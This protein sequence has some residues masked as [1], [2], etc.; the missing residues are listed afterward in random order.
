MFYLHPNKP[1]GFCAAVLE[2]FSNKVDEIADGATK[3]I[4]EVL[5]DPVGM[6]CAVLTLIVG[7]IRR[8]GWYTLKCYGGILLNYYMR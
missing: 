7:L 6:S 4:Q 1:N 5:V 8:A 2:E 3:P